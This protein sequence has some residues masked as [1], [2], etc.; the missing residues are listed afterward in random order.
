MEMNKNKDKEK[1]GERVSGLVVSKCIEF[2]N[3]A[4][5]G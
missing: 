1:E 5:K 2:I 4:A 3:Y